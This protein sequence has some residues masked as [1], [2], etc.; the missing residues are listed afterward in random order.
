V[1]EPRRRVV[2]PQAVPNPREQQCREKLRARL[3]KERAALAR[4]QKRLCRAFHA[5][6][7]A[8][9]TVA[10]LERQIAREEG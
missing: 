6:D 8:Q 1:T 10:R 5:M 4:W 7:K 2:R 3:R 9:R